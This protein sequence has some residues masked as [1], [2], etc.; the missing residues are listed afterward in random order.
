VDHRPVVVALAGAL[1]LFAI[2]FIGCDKGTGNGDATPASA[3]QVILDVSSKVIYAT[4]VDLNTT[5]DTLLQAVNR[6]AQTPNAA[7]LALAQQAWRNTRIPWERSEGFLFG[8][9]ATIPVDAAIDTWPLNQADLDTILKSNVPLTKEYVDSLDFSLKGFHTLEYLLFGDSTNPNAIVRYPANL[10]A[11]QLE[12][13]KAA[14]ASLKSETNILVQA[15]NPA[16]GNF[17]GSFQSAGQGS[18]KYKSEEDALKELLYSV[19]NICDE[20]ANEKMYHAF[21][22]DPPDRNQEE[23]RFSN[24]STTD[25]ANNLRSVRNV[26]F[27]NYG[28]NSGQG[29]KALLQAKNPAL[30]GEVEAQIDSAINRTLAMGVFSEDILRAK[31]KIDSASAKIRALRSTLMLRVAPAL[32]LE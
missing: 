7:N 23:S 6:L 15:W 4:Y 32:G 24:N 9:V 22:F 3:R 17:L 31:D 1:S 28:S 27:C 2:A 14:A 19:I 11:R 26:Y 5:A 12:Y 13:L 21:R 29:L 8:P 30:A 16:S 20:V 10:T 25:F 18:T